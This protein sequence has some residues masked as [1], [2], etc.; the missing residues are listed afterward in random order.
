MDMRQACSCNSARRSIFL[1]LL[2]LLVRLLGLLLAPSLEFMLL[3]EVLE[4]R[5]VLDRI[6]LHLVDHLKPPALAD[7]ASPG[8]SFLFRLL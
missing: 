3:I 5:L 1:F 2:L 4:I 6:S 8:C 7:C